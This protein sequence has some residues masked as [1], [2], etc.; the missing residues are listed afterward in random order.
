MVKMKDPKVINSNSIGDPAHF[1]ALEDLERRFESLPQAPADQGQVGLVVMKGHGG[2]RE[3]PEQVLL[4][5]PAELA[6]DGDH[7]QEDLDGEKQLTVMQFDVAELIANGQPLPLFG[8][9]LFLDLDLSTENLPAGSR[10][11]VGGAIL[12]VTPVPHNGCRK[13]RGRFGDNAL[14]FVSKKE[15]RHRNL[16]GIYMRVLEGGEVGPGDPVEVISRP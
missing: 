5:P 6:G 10:V 3:T 4:S 13:F 7:A 15:L 16:R 12:Q 1:Q 14:Q 11:R 9:N 2:Q 8:D